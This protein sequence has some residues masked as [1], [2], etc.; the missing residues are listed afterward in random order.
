[1]GQATVKALGRADIDLPRA[2]SPTRRVDALH[3]IEVGASPS[4]SH[5]EVHPNTRDEKY[6]ASTLERT[7]T[8]TATSSRE[9]E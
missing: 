3:E 6:K 4:P 7:L 2:P 5:L 9:Q 1:M 8:L